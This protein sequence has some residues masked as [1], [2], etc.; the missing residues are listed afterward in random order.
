[1][2][3]RAIT[4]PISFLTASASNLLGKQTYRVTGGDQTRLSYA[5]ILFECEALSSKREYLGEDNLPQSWFEDCCQGD[6]PGIID[7]E[8]G[9][10]RLTNAI[11][12]LIATEHLARQANR[13]MRIK[14]R[15]KRK[16]MQAAAAGGGNR[17]DEVFLCVSKLIKVS[18]EIIE[19]PT[20]WSIFPW[21]YH[22]HVTCNLYK[23]GGLFS[24]AQPGSLVIAATSLSLP[25]SS[26]L[27]IYISMSEESMTERS[28]LLDRRRRRSSHQIYNSVADLPPVP[29]FPSLSDI[30]AGN[31]NSAPPT[32]FTP[33]YNASGG[34]SS[35]TQGQHHKFKLFNKRL[36]SYD[37]DKQGLIK[38]STG[39]RVWYES[40]SS[41]G[42]LERTWIFICR[43]F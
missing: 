39:V 10:D 35:L 6:M 26:H 36:G 21:P 31:N 40:Y 18:D 37:E 13:V 32:F 4:N 15:K 33:S 30:Q 27:A 29:S 3:T 16:R 24:F 43:R 12:T 11:G 8:D 23:R 34:A 1:M 19:Y 9:V 14:E 38:E 7:Q 42:I 25:F 22:W 5:A 20:V 17:S 41:I 28:S 2:A